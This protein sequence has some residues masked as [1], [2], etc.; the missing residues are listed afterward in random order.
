MGR[1]LELLSMLIEVKRVNCTQ[2]PKPLCPYGSWAILAWI[3]FVGL[4]ARL[5]LSL[6]VAGMA[7]V[8]RH[9]SSMLTWYTIG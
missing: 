3:C 2:F 4:G 8:A 5:H 1:Y 6:H 9:R 7:S